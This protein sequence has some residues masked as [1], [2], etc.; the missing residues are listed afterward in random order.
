MQGRKLL[1]LRQQESRRRE[2]RR[3]KMKMEMKPKKSFSPPS[4]PP[5]T[6]CVHSSSTNRSTPLSLLVIA[7]YFLSVETGGDFGF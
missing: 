3:R 6:F 7:G 5:P 4:H 2:E 1:D